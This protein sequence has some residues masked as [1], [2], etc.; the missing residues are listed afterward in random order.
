MCTCEQRTQLTGTNSRTLRRID[1][2]L[3]PIIHGPKIS[4]AISLIRELQLLPLPDHTPAV[5]IP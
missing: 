2:L 1:P 4:R 3:D 5:R